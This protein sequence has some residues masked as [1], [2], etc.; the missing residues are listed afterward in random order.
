MFWTELTCIAHVR[1]VSGVI[2]RVSAFTT[3]MEILRSGELRS[4][5][6][7]FTITDNLYNTLHGKFHLQFIYWRDYELPLP[8]MMSNCINSDMDFR[9][10]CGMT[11][12]QPWDALFVHWQKIADFQLMISSQTI[13][14]EWSYL[15]RMLAGSVSDY[16]NNVEAFWHHVRMLI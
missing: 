2:V 7:D 12:C 15:F 6:S 11:W 8:S 1:F 3:F 14:L 13:T 16:N 9:R 5:F 4:F 10:R